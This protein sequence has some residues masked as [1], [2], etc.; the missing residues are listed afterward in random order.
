MTTTT[1]MTTTKPATATATMTAATAEEPRL[2]RD[3]ERN[4]HYL[5]QHLSRAEI[6]A[7]VALDVSPGELVPLHR[8]GCTPEQ[9]VAYREAGMT[10]VRQIVRLRG[11]GW[12][13]AYLA[14]TGLEPGVALGYLACGITSPAKMHRLLGVGAR[15]E[16][17]RPYVDPSRF[18]SALHEVEPLPRT[19]LTVEGAFGPLQFVV[20]AGL[21]EAA[22][23]DA[24]DD[25]QDE[26]A[27]AVLGHDAA[28]STAMR[29]HHQWRRGLDA[30]WDELAAILGTAEDGATARMRWLRAVLD[31]EH[32]RFDGHLPAMPRLAPPP[33]CPACIER[34]EFV[35]AR[36][37]RAVNGTSAP[38]RPTAGA[39]EEAA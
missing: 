21:L 14:A 33:P 4:G 35:R 3:L 19:T 15:P 18:C 26:S 28:P 29:L 23:P 38:H 12:S 16:A 11:C 7:L 6:A 37:A 8:V 31:A 1:T 36:A 2:H 9:L 27:M 34:D 24:A 30:D 39:A 10:E 20:T 32:T 22:S 25:L 13:P 5:F 17:L